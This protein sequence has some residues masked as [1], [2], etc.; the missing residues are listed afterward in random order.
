MYFSCVQSEPE[1]KL[2]ARNFTSNGVCQSAGSTTAA[3]GY[4]SRKQ[5]GFPLEHLKV[6]YN[7]IHLKV[8]YNN[9]HLKVQYNNMYSSNIKSIATHHFWW[10]QSSTFHLLRVVTWLKTP[11]HPYK[12]T[13]SEGVTHH[14]EDIAE[15]N[16]EVSDSE[17]PNSGTEEEADGW[18][19]KGGADQVEHK[20]KEVLHSRPKSCR[21]YLCT[22][23]IS[24]HI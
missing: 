16:Q 23:L 6:Q 18:C 15:G 13:R 7:N 3:A 21:D 4:L 19:R 24:P 2:H 11:P 1:K 5:A 10:G 12:S 14:H 8:Q 22:T 17:D 9:R 20:E